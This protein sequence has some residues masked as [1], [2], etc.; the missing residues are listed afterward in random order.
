MAYLAT[1]QTQRQAAN[2][3][4][5]DGNSKGRCSPPIVTRPGEILSA[6][7]WGREAIPV[8]KRLAGPA[9]VPAL[10]N[11]TGNLV[12]PSFLRSSLGEKK[13][14]HRQSRRG[15]V[16]P[17]SSTDRNPDRSSTADAADASGAT[18]IRPG[19]GHSNNDSA[20][21]HSDRNRAHIVGK[22]GR[23]GR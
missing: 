13:Q 17:D 23:C 2:N 3:H 8:A 11:K 19:Y 15:L 5:Q 16:N 4:F 21:S 9:A 18:D 22:P 20:G 6:I 10:T 1:G 14:P 7:G 12:K